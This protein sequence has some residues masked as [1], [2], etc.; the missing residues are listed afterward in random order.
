MIGNTL[1][2]MVSWIK[3]YGFVNVTQAIFE[4]YV[5]PSKKK[6]EKSIKLLTLTFEI[7]VRHDV[8]GLLSSKGGIEQWMGWVS[9]LVDKYLKRYTPVSLSCLSYTH[10]K[11]TNMATDIDK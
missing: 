11:L 6:E 10:S 4:I 7:I 9:M 3:H 8:F 1:I 5:S 2:S